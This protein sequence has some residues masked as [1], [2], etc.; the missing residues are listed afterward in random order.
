VP[1]ATNAIIPTLKAGTLYRATTKELMQIFE[2]LNDDFA[3]NYRGEQLTIGW[4]KNGF[5]VHLVEPVPVASIVEEPE[6]KSK[7]RAA[8]G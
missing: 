4:S 8:G 6:G 5:L 3:R 2:S 7:A 1:N